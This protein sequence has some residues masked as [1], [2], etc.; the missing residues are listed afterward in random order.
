MTFNVYLAPT[1]NLMI[2]RYCKICVVT[3]GGGDLR[4]ATT[5][6]KGGKKIM[7]FV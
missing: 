2:C 4:N 5:C 6:D 1:R 7:K 3:L